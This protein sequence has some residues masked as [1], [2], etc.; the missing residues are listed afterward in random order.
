MRFRSL[1]SGAVLAALLAAGC[2][3]ENPQ[4]IPSQ[5]ADELIA[6]VDAAGQATAAGDCAQAHDAVADARRRVSE[7]PR[8]VNRRLERNLQDWLRYLD[9]RIR[10]DCVPA[11]ATATPT[12]TE[13][14]TETPTPTKTPKPTPTPTE[15]PTPTATETPTATAT[16]TP[17]ATATET[18]TPSP[19]TT[20]ES[21]G[22]EPSGASGVS[23][24]E[25]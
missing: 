14:A 1:L 10:V 25:R 8:T 18:P 7:L 12:P 9:R 5:D 17:T 2:G 22:A 13:T 21:G 19:T 23:Q 4:L 24:G 16:P 15:T 20:G 6:V 11:G 3:R